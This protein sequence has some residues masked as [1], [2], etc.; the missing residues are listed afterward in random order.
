M[1]FYL[2]SYIADNTARPLRPFRHIV[3]SIRAAISQ[4]FGLRVVAVRP[5]ETLRLYC[6]LDAIYHVAGE[7]MRGETVHLLSPGDQIVL[8]LGAHYGL[9][10][11]KIATQLPVFS[12]VIA[13]EAHPTNYAVLKRNIALNHLRNIRA[14]NFAVAG[15][16]GFTSISTF[17]GISTHYT[18]TK[19]SDMSAPASTVPCYRLLDILELLD[20]DHVDLVK[21]DIEGM[22]LEVLQSSF[23]ALGNRILKLDIEVHRFQDLAP[24]SKIL[25]S[26]GFAVRAKR[27]GILSRSYRVLAEKIAPGS[28]LPSEQF[29]NKF[30][31]SAGGQPQGSSTE[32]KVADPV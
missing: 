29:K 20:F 8:D 19:Q 23:P 10:S 30:P 13:V 9:V 26:N 24:V 1:P 31:I 5:F 2:L 21:M 7:H 16:T 4:S 28:F 32:T 27:A 17:D 12:Q 14:F 15:Y 3:R 6:D 25:R 11:T 22:E 18:M